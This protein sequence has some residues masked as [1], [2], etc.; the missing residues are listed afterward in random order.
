M[1]SAFEQK[2]KN[3][4][5]KYRENPSSETEHNMEKKIERFLNS[6]PELE[7]FSITGIIRS[8]KQSTINWA[9]IFD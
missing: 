4:L 5:I 9:E 2:Y 6:L 8:L 7:A 1:C 3:E